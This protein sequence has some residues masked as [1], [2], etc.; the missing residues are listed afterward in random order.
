MGTDNG[1]EFKNSFIINYL[2]KNNIRLVNGAPYNPRAQGV[3]E[4]IH[5]T[6][7]NSL[8]SIFL[9]NLKEFNIE[10]ALKKVMNIYN[11]TKHRITKFTPNEIFFSTNKDLFLKVK[12]HIIENYNKSNANLILNFSEKE[13]CLLRNDFIKSSNKT[14]E[15]YVIL[16]KNKVKKNIVLL[17]Y[18]LRYLKY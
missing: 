11:K 6:I 4:R 14:K 1:K 8:L 15:G 16:L 3:V 13:K 9:E 10:R 2:Q 7:R 17:K 18:V 12:N 5:I